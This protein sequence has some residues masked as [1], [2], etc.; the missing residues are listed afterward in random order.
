MKLIYCLMIFLL[1]FASTGQKV[2]ALSIGDP[3]P[4]ITITNVYNYPVSPIHLS[5][6]KGKLVILDFWSTWCSA[7]IQS[8]PTME[9]L[10][11]QFG[12]KLQIILVNTYKGDSIQRVKSFFEKRKVRTGESV[13]LPYSLLQSSLTQYFP[14]KFV[15]HYV[16]INEEGKVAAITSASEI[17]ENNIREIIDGKNIKL[18]TKKDNLTFDYTK[19]LFVKDNGGNG[20]D[21]LYRSVITHYKEGL[22]YTVGH[23][24]SEGKTRFF[25][26]NQPLAALLSLAF[27][28]EMALPK[29]RR[30]YSGDSATNL[31]AKIESDNLANLYCYE[32]IA[33]AVSHAVLLHYIRQ[34][35]IRFFDV[36]AH[37]ETRK[38]KC[39]LL[40][41]ANPDKISYT[42]YS[43]PR[44]EYTD[45]SE[46]KFLQDVPVSYVVKI[47]NN[48]LHAPLIDETGIKQPVDINLPNDLSNEK[49]I[50]LALKNAGFTITTSEK[51]MEVTVISTQ[52]FSPK[53]NSK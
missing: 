22:G 29:N 28:E 31:K 40:H 12:E 35:M 45:K 10:Q 15:P 44:A 24:A 1:P 26:L 21:F 52:K 11:K 47:L 34:D 41:A 25:A 14:Y 18:H 39:Y 30:Y 4:D 53:N 23:S 19:P 6:L 17:T 46:K 42:R 36:V 2:K 3:V 9:R 20:D 50:L 5:D 13:D 32:I 49:A 7:C 43:I 48:F 8:F 38:I 37:K 51:E 33:P 27:P 16:W